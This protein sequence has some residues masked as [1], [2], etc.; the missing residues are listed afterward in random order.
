[1]RRRYRP[2]QSP[3]KEFVNSFH[4]NEVPL[5]YYNP[6]QDPYLEGYF[7]ND[8]VNQ[9]MQEAGFLYRKSNQYPYSE[10]RTT[11]YN[12]FFR[13]NSFRVPPANVL[14]QREGLTQRAKDILE[15]KSDYQSTRSQ[16]MKKM[17][18]SDIFAKSPLQYPLIGDILSKRPST[19]G[20]SHSPEKR[21][22]GKIRRGNRPSS[23][24]EQFSAVIF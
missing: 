3:R 4:V 6:L 8:K 20:G 24:D 16:L 22:P 23:R 9:H 14:R 19:T 15:P 7:N 12:K 5:P 21:G 17:S 11:N 10:R 18:D 1:M 13:N 2:A